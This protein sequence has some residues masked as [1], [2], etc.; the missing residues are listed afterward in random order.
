M[1]EKE[2][3]EVFFGIPKQYRANAV[4]FFIGPP[5]VWRNLVRWL[6]AHP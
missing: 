1:T 2:I 3:H 4:W 6:R 5:R